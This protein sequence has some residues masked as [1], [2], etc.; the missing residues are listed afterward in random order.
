M[1]KSK[2]LLVMLAIVM[3]ASIALV[4]CGKSEEA[5]PPADNSGQQNAGTQTEQPKQEEPQELVLNASTE[6]PSLNPN[7]AT[8]STSGE[9]LRQVMEGLVRLDKD[10]K[11]VKGSGMAEDW[12]ISE[13]GL[14]ITFKIKDNV[15]WSNGD[16]VTAEDFEYAWKQVLNPETAADY[17]YQLFYLKNGEKYNAGEVSADEVGVKALDEKTLEVT[18]EAPV[19]YFISLTAFYS[20]YP[21]PSKVAKE[22]PDWAADAETYVSNGP[23]KLTK[24]EHDSEVVVEKND[25]YWNADNIKLNK[26]TWMMVN[27]PNTEY[28][29]F[30]SGDL[31]VAENPPSDLLKQLLDSGEAKA[32]NILGTY[33][34]MFNVEKEPFNNAN[35]RKAFTLAID[36]KLLIDNVTQGGQVPALGFVPPGSSPDLGFDF[37][38]KAGNYYNDADVEKAK[39]Y[40]KK[41]MEELGITQLPEITLMFNTSEGHQKI[42][43]AIQEMWKKNLGVEVKLQNQEWK[44]YLETLKSG[45]FQIGRLGWLADYFDPMTFLDMWITDGGNN[46]TN[47]S[48]KEYDD[49]IAKAKS[50]DDQSVRGEAMLKAEKILMDEMPIAP[51][52]FYTDAY[53]M[54]PWVKG[55]IRH[56]DGSN[57]YTQAYIEGR[58]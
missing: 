29:L 44:V 9:I 37:R 30:K 58:K 32:P 41:G 48:N 5:N 36:R 4:G 28:Q 21:V 6:P 13:D 16:P 31:D 56:P 55:A 50:T 7:T 47:W 40:L 42:A 39:E 34:Y 14:T 45:D 24:W 11:V 49:L 25:K 35:I 15:F 17:A 38:E 20:L 2:W 54:Q 19:P 22:N 57:D 1:K 12:T 52:Y 18:L 46:D 23:F 26:I 51:I 10:S 3:I 53:M 8:D 27:D 43:Q 33:M